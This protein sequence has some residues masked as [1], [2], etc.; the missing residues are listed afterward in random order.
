MTLIS[1]I[2]PV[3]IDVEIDRLQKALY[4]H[5]TSTN[6][7]W[8]DYE[9]YH[10][11]Y[12]NETND[13]RKWEVYVS[14]KEYKEVLFD[15]KFNATSFF[16]VSDTYEAVDQIGMFQTNVSLIMQL[17]LDEMYPSI[18]HRADE[19]AHRDVIIGLN[20]SNTNNKVT[21]VT[22]GIRNVYTEIGYGA[23]K[24]DDMHPHHVFRV[25][26]EVIF[27]ERCTP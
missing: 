1:K 26:M 12:K 15:D 3:G 10:R 4:K 6:I 7:G 9:S 13:N 5:L 8:T 21:G 17:K 2:S 27:E 18:A 24:F 25:N 14:G 22:K 19:E 16:I 20:N 11:A 23:N